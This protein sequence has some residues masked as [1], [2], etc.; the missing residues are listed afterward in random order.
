MSKHKHVPSLEVCVYATH[1]DTIFKDLECEAL[2]VIHP[3]CKSAISCHCGD[4]L[5]R[6]NTQY[7]MLTLM[8]A[9]GVGSQVIDHGVLYLFKEL[10]R[11]LG[12]LACHLLVP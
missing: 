5:Y 10:N 1:N 3:V 6:D 8:T 4:D 11:P 7:Y 9:T 12:H 2:H